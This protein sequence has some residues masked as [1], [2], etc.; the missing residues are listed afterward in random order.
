MCKNI[1][2]AI[3]SKSKWMNLNSNSI[4]IWMQSRLQTKR[5]IS[6]GQISNELF[7][8]LIN[9]KIVIDQRTEYPSYYWSDSACLRSMSKKKNKI[10]KEI[11]WKKK[12][13]YK[14]KSKN[15]IKAITTTK[16]EERNRLNA[17]STGS[18]S[19]SI[20]RIS[21][22]KSRIQMGSCITID[23]RVLPIKCTVDRSVENSFFFF[24]LKWFFDCSLHHHH[25]LLLLLYSNSA[26]FV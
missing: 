17:T 7:N 26:S 22:V 11:Q 19:L 6:G 15:K 12:Y 18:S 14:S 1:I 20:G 3:N 10:L 8:S 16:N 21:S 24:L 25:R 23:S 4:A 9:I 5:K 13:K 2:K